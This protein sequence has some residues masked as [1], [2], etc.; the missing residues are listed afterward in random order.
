MKLFCLDSALLKYLSAMAVHWP[1][2]GGDLLT[3][4]LNDS[5]FLLRKRNLP[6]RTN[7]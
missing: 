2:E 6:T 1:K 4:I 3:E 7:F 5:C